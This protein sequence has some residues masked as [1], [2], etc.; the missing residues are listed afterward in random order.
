MQQE[1][2]EPAWCLIK[3]GVSRAGCQRQH[4]DSDTVPA[5]DRSSCSLTKNTARIQPQHEGCE[6]CSPPQHL[7]FIPIFTSLSAQRQD[8]APAAHTKLDLLGFGGATTST[9]PE[10]THKEADAAAA[11]AASTQAT[12]TSPQQQL[13]VS[14]SSH[15]YQ[16]H[17]LQLALEYS[18]G[19]DWQ[20]QPLDTLV[21]VMG[22]PPGWMCGDDCSSFDFWGGGSSL[23][24]RTDDTSVLP[25]QLAAV[26]DPPV[27]TRAPKLCVTVST[28]SSEIDSLA[29]PPLRMP[30]AAPAQAATRVEV[31]PTGLSSSKH[32]G[33]F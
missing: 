20:P 9:A 14:A 5:S 21:A 6:G 27:P 23:L 11:G 31:T 33:E 28:V 32:L 4:N 2:Q 17:S 13:G 29:F 26:P 3:G 19:V 24:V 10:K 18:S 25:A 12:A 16:Q 8:S 22:A 1:Q 7:S 30:A 15:S